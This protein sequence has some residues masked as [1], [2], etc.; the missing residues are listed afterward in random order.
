MNRWWLWSLT[1]ALLAA[2]TAPA[3]AGEGEGFLA[4]HHVL[5][6]NLT[7]LVNFLIFAFILVRFAGPKLKAYFDGSAG[8]YKAKVAEAAQVL[9]DAQKV[10]Q[11]WS[12]RQAQLEQEVER[13]KR[14]AQS[15]TEAQA[16]E[17]LANAQRTAERIIA[18]TK[19]SVEGEILLAKDRLRNELVDGLL[20]ETEKQLQARLSP[21]HQHLLIEEA[22]KKLEA[23]Q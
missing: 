7:A 8:E 18:D 1:A 15:L 22:I 12:A 19:R 14:D 17:I 20:A 23:S 21:S 10:Y 11:D 6:E 13:I 5:I 4:T 16:R 3:L 2:T 9:A